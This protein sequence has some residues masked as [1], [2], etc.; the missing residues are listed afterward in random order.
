MQE[1]TLSV[2][3]VATTNSTQTLVT[4]EDVR[5]GILQSVP[6]ITAAII[7]QL[8]ER[9]MLSPNRERFSVN[10][11]TVSQ[12]YFIRDEHTGKTVCNYIVGEELAE[13]IKELLLQGTRPMSVSKISCRSCRHH[14]FEPHSMMYAEC[15]RKAVWKEDPKTGEK[16]KIKARIASSERRA[17]H[18]L[19]CGP[20]AR[21]YE[22][23][24]TFWGRVKELLKQYWGFL[25]NG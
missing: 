10:Q 19:C 24:P 4:G 17:T 2:P 15:G 16:T 8:K 18:Y 25:L 6:T 12:Y 20:S 3:P 1:Y 23:I 9:Q 5:S 21:Y 22:P 13:S 7:Q 14:V 11:I